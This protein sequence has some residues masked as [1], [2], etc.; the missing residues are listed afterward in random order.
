MAWIYHEQTE[1]WVVNL[2]QLLDRG[3][4]CHKRQTS[5]HHELQGGCSSPV[6][7][8][9]TSDHW[10]AG[11]NPL[12]CMFYHYFKLLVPC[13]CLF[14]F[15]LILFYDELQSSVHDVGQVTMFTM[16]N[17]PGINHCLPWATCPNW[18]GTRIVCESWSE[19]PGFKS[20]VDCYVVFTGVRQDKPVFTTTSRCS[21]LQ[22][23]CSP[24]QAGVHHYKP[25]VHHYKPSV[26]HYKP[27]V[28]HY[29]P[30]VHHYKPVF[31]TT[32]Q[33]SPLQ[34]SV[35]HDKPVFT[36]ISQCSPRQASVHHSDKHV[37]IMTSQCVSPWKQ[38][39]STSSH[40]LLWRYIFIAILK[41]CLFS[42]IHSLCVINSYHGYWENY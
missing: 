28:H 33:C 30:S 42:A 21:P 25:S 34:A 10:V 13:S 26:H 22:A 40:P 16:R 4:G 41:M 5:V 20:S 36:M 31:T 3:L 2:Q 8:N 27:S 29:K 37:F 17:K 38:W 7:A 11:S 19:G 32:S 9:W 6:I 15:G 12:T 24:L 23:K 35:H 14:W 18:V 1:H 39:Y